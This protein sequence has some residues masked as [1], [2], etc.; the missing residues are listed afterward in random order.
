MQRVVELVADVGTAAD[1]LAVIVD[2]TVLAAVED[3]VVL[4]LAQTAAVGGFV[5]LD[6]AH[7]VVERRGDQMLL[8]R[9]VELGDIEAHRVDLRQLEP[10]RV[11]GEERIGG[12]EHEAPHVDVAREGD[13][14]VLAHRHLALLR[15]DDHALAVAHHKLL[16]AGDAQ[17]VVGQRQ[18]GVAALGGRLQRDGVVVGLLRLVVRPHIVQQF[19]LHRDQSAAL[20]ERHQAGARQRVD[21]RL[22][23]DEVEV[24]RVGELVDEKLALHVALLHIII[25]P[26]DGVHLV[27]ALYLA[28][29]AKGVVARRLEGGKRAVARLSAQRG[30]IE[31]VGGHIP[32][33]RLAVD[34]QLVVGVGIGAVVVALAVV[35]QRHFAFG[36]VVAHRD[37]IVADGV[38]VDVYFHRSA[39]RHQLARCDGETLRGDRDEGCTATAEDER[40]SVCLVGGH[41]AG[42]VHHEAARIVD[43]GHDVLHDEVLLIGLELGEGILLG[44]HACRQ[45]LGELSANGLLEIVGIGEQH[46][47]GGELGEL[48]NRFVAFQLCPALGG[49]QSGAAPVD[50]ASPAL[51]AA[52]KVVETARGAIDGAVVGTGTVVQLHRLVEIEQ[53]GAT[54]ADDAERRTLLGL[55]GGTL[56]FIE[57]AVFDQ[58]RGELREIDHILHLLLAALQ[59]LHRLQPLVE[60]HRRLGHQ[61]GGGG[62]IDQLGLLPYAQLHQLG[63]DRRQT[64]LHRASKRLVGRPEIG[65][66]LAVGLAH[67]V[68]GGSAVEIFQQL[69]GQRGRVKL[70]GGILLGRQ[71]QQQ[72]CEQEGKNNSFHNMQKYTNRQCFHRCGDR[73][74]QH[75]T[76]NKKGARAK[77]VFRIFAI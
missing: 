66:Q 5:N 17:L 12:V 13:V 55:P 50:T 24:Q 72:K 8:C 77:G 6:R 31:L 60:R 1:I 23:L 59:H 62:E 36:D 33:N 22:G 54:L 42:A 49:G 51:P 76:V 63:V 35:E 46:R 69:V 37:T 14:A 4:R 68:L 19:V 44:A 41:K 28:E 47:V 20:V 30:E 11:V 9:V 39:L 27:D 65:H 7:Q 38:A 29:L 52:L 71:R 73:K 18:F 3:G 70:R 48:D 26:D 15:V 75:G 74:C 40:G 45:R 53:N 16:H 43:A 2:K 67:L 57:R 64:L 32:D 61:R 25:D 10:E 58:P 21:H 34:I 56:G